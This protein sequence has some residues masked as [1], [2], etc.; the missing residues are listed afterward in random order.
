M[1]F[2]SW[3]FIFAFLPVALA[4]FFLLGRPKL[5]LLVASLIFC[6]WGNPWNLAVLLISIGVNFAIASRFQRTLTDRQRKRW[7]WT[8]LG[9]N[10]SFL[11]FFKYVTHALPLGISFFTIQQIAFLVDAY[12]GMSEEKSL[13][14][15][16]LFVGFFPKL[17]LGPITSHQDF[18]PQ[19][20]DP[21]RRNFNSDSFARGCFLFA[22]GLFK[23]A[24]IADTLA[25]WVS[26]GFDE[27]ISLDFF[28]A[29]KT[30]LCYSFQ[31]Y[32]DFSGYTD[33]AMGVAAMFNFEL[34][35]NFRSPFR[36]K[37]VVEF[38]SRWHVTLTQFI[39]TYIF[40][41]LVRAMPAMT[42]GWMLLA[43]FL[44]MI[45]SGIW[46]GA[47]WTFVLYGA[48]HGVALVVNQLWK[49]RKRP[50]PAPLAWA[51]TFL[52]VNASFVIFRARELS[53]ANRMFR[54]MLGLSGVIIPRMAGK[55]LPKF[56]PHEWKVG[57]YL[58]PTDY[59]ILI[60]LAWAFLAIRLSPTVEE[61][62][63]NFR[64]TEKYGAWAAALFVM[65]LFGLNRVSEF[66]YANF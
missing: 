27:S 53:D 15:Y 42:T 1:P 2:N 49:L 22:L 25:G 6:A 48:M 66:I 28:A 35:A 39:T 12:E 40:T 41:P 60:F 57:S 52:F 19:L 4:G 45:I 38:W 59:L 3:I 11:C 5:W 55:K 51:L 36:A 10:I 8:G 23:K 58:Q 46:H 62:I 13:L 33:M 16:A 65:G 32:F 7:L 50:L 14:D 54:G 29:W 31:L 44:S 34:P 43:T 37:N 24:V 63:K 18:A 56:F 17:A 20:H 64:P 9:L 26:P 30:S 21:S 47:G 61:R